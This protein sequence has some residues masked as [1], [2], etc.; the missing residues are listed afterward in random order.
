MAALV[1]NRIAVVEPGTTLS[2][3]GRI[4]ADTDLAIVRSGDAL[5]GVLTKIDLIAFLT[6]SA[7][8]DGEPAVGRDGA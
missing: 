5:L 1:S 6:D 3:L 2:V 8:R 7:G 4:F